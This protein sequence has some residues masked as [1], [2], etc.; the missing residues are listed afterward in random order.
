[1]YKAITHKCLFGK[2][3]EKR[4]RRIY[5][6]ARARDAN[7]FCFTDKY[8]PRRE[9]REKSYA[10]NIS[11]DHYRE[12]IFTRVRVPDL[13]FAQVEPAWVKSNQCENWHDARCSR[14]RHKTLT[15]P[16]S[17]RSISFPLT[18]V[19]YFLFINQFAGFT[20]ARTRGKYEHYLVRERSSL[21]FGP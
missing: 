11:I 18:E 2:K 17:P 9:H 13:T 7:E 16:R 14:P 5:D 8:I 6:N 12:T 21:H 10:L 19:K 4:V 3:R 15:P 20:S 1:M